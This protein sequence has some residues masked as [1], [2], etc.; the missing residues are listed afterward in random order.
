MLPTRL[1]SSA[2]QIDFSS[3][4]SDIEKGIE[5]QKLIMSTKMPTWTKNITSDHGTTVLEQQRHAGHSLSLLS[6]TKLF[7][8][9]SISSFTTRKVIERVTA[10]TFSNIDMNDSNNSVL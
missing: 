6:K 3:Q 5:K 9:P 10:V 4:L 8:P 7:T 2:I 1:E